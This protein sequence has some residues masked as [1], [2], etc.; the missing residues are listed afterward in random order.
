M[1]LEP[2]CT[3]SITRSW[4]PM[5]YSSKFYQRTGYFYVGHR[6]S[7]KHIYFFS[8]WQ[9]DQLFVLR[10]A[11]ITSNGV[12]SGV[13]LILT[14]LGSFFWT[15]SKTRNHPCQKKRPSLFLTTQLQNKWKIRTFNISMACSSPLCLALTLSIFKRV[16]IE[17]QI[18]S[19]F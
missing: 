12:K 15:G 1:L 10:T 5:W 18:Q 7:T 17:E 9:L 16:N 11:L 19:N 2:R 14:V 6:K 3:D 4:H 13:T 8:T